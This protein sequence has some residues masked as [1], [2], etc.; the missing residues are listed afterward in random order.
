MGEGRVSKLS[1]MRGVS[2]LT[3]T[4][5]MLDEKSTASL[6]AKDKLKEAFETINY[7]LQGTATNFEI[8]MTESKDGQWLNKMQKEAQK[9]GTLQNDS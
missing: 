4:S 7:N 1:A 9:L 8:I 5:S 2:G 3:K 6:K